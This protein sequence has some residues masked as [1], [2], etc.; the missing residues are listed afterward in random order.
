MCKDCYN[1]VSVLD[2]FNN[3]IS[4]ERLIGVIEKIIMAIKTQE[5][6]KNNNNNNNKKQL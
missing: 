4:C 5:K 3:G 6:R 1:C 2:Q